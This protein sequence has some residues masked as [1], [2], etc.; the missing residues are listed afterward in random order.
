MKFT[1]K[2]ETDKQG[3]KI[4]GIY[5]NFSHLTIFKLGLNKEINASVPPGKGPP[6]PFEVCFLCFSF[7]K[8]LLISAS[9]PSGRGPLLFQQCFSFLF[10]YY[11]F[12]KS[13]AT[14]LQFVSLSS[15]L[16]R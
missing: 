3:G 13:F 15:S 11:F 9:L 6:L 12:Q 16:F 14:V 2:K 5:W 8:V 10:L 1:D 7:N 4:K